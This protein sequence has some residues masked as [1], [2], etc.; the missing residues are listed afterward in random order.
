LKRCFAGPIVFDFEIGPVREQHCQ[1]VDTASPNGSETSRLSVV[2]DAIDVRTSAQE[3]FYNVNATRF[4]PH[5]EHEWRRVER[6]WQI[7]IDVDCTAR[8][9]QLDT[10]RNAA[11]DC[12]GE[13]LDQTHSWLSCGVKMKRTFGSKIVQLHDACAFEFIQNP[14]VYQLLFMPRDSSK[15]PSAR[16]PR[17]S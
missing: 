8:E 3:H 9:Q 2:V 16:T 12:L 5:G 11:L 14:F 10:I 6:A 7:N 15:G 13:I 1:D 4:G 17:C